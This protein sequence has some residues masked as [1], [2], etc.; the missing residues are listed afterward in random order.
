[1][2]YEEALAWLNGE[3]SMQYNIP[4]DPLETWQVRV[5]QADAAM[6][7]QAYWFVKAHKEGL[8]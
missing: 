7:Q 5:A 3:R 4:M 8:V 2:N 6:A 1:M